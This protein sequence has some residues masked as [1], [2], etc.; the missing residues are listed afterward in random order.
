[1]IFFNNIYFATYCKEYDN[2]LFT[3]TTNCIITANVKTLDRF[4]RKEHETLTDFSFTF[5]VRALQY[6]F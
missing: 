4:Y 3:Q 6:I 2:Q 5:R 1:M